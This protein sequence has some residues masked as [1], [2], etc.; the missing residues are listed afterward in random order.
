M[1]WARTNVFVNAN[2][3]E[4]IPT[5]AELLIA[6]A[7]VQWFVRRHFRVGGNSLARDGGRFMVMGSK[8]WPLGAAV[9]LAAAMG[10][11]GND[12]TPTATP[13][14][15]PAAPVTPATPAAPTTP[16]TPTTP[17]ATETPAMPAAP[18]AAPTPVTPT[19]PS[20][21][22]DATAATTSQADALIKQA[23]DYVKNNKLDLASDAVTKLQA[24]K[25]S[26]PAS[27]GPQ[28]DQLK[29]MVDAAQVQNGKVPSGVKLPGM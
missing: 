22:A 17:T 10:G 11:C 21:A 15:T 19:T 25:G 14:P 9:V 2:G 24:M 29:A 1:L 6:N 8:M 27:Y 13:A 18:A 26:L 3:F 7:R 20:A 12:N 16:T 4:E 28:I 5:S 23:T